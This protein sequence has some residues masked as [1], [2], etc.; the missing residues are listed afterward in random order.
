MMAHLSG[1]V[2]AVLLAV[3]G[4]VVGRLLA[5]A[6][7]GRNCLRRLTTAE[8]AATAGVLGLAA[9]TVTNLVLAYLGIFRPLTVLLTAASLAVI[10][11]TRLR[12]RGGLRDLVPRLTA[13][14]LPIFVLAAGVCVYAVLFRFDAI[15]GM[16]DPGVYTASAIELSRTGDFGWRDRNVAQYGFRPVRQLFEDLH[17]LVAGKPR[18]VR[19]P[20]FYV[21][22]PSGGV[23]EP[24]FLHGYETWLALAYSFGGPQAT[25]CVNALFAALALLAVSCALARVLNPAAGICTAL[26]LA[27][28][29]AEMWFARYTSNELMVQALVWGFLLLYFIMVQAEEDEGV[30]RLAFP[31]VLLAL[32]VAALTKIAAWGFLPVVAFDAALRRAR[33]ITP[34]PGNA[35]AQALWPSPPYYRCAT[36]MPAAHI[37][38]LLPLIAGAAWLHAWLFA[39]FYLFGTWHHTAAHLGMS[40]SF[41]GVLFVLG[42]AAAASAGSLGRPLAF[43]FERLASHKA[44]RVLAPAAA[45]VFGAW[46][47]HSQGRVV[48]SPKLTDVYK[49]NTNVA[50]F[51]LY[52]SGPLFLMAAASLPLMLQWTGR[53]GL[54]LLALLVGV[55]CALLVHRNLDSMHPWGA[56]RWVIVLIPAF[57]A[58]AAFPAAACFHVRRRM[59]QLA[60]AA[61]LAVVVWFAWNAAPQLLRARHYRGA[62]PAVDRLAQ[63]LQPNDLNLMQPTWPVAQ[64][65]AFIKARFDIDCYVQTQSEVAWRQTAA[66][67]RKHWERGANTVY[68]T[69]APLTSDTIRLDLID[70]VGQEPL[71]YEIVRETNRKLPKGSEM[72]SHTLYLYRF[73][74]DR[75]PADWWP[76]KPLVDKRPRSAPPI[77]LKMDGL[78]APYLDGFFGPS[79]C[80]P[81]RVFRWTNGMGAI[82]IGEL[83]RFPLDGLKIRLTVRMGS[84]RP[85]RP[86]PVRVHWFLDMLDKDRGKQVHV[87]DVVAE[88]ADYSL[89]LDPSQLQPD[90]ILYLSSGRNRIDGKMPPGVV[91][92]AVEYLRIEQ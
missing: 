14:D 81:D 11:L 8:S 36:R 21:T 53:R 40:F 55:S 88:L 1:L 20:G 91:G 68:I 29:P 78:A 17:D 35:D 51:A 73:R 67:G 87:S 27:I 85:A 90:S 72:L 56:R 10:A 39:D 74:F 44:M 61:Y 79:P 82:R 23:V 86:E 77:E 22:Q 3:L 60:G 52:F 24:Q 30:P 89:E 46:L 69:D 76:F 28:N 34:Q 64:W 59:P 80:G 84:G 49:E 92:V 54:G 47:L 12:A 57:C 31:V 6:G 19:F 38:V 83:L 71:R 43:Q 4:L 13:R 41:L 50:E 5:A 70:L 65:A 42:T 63:K 45:A 66:I 75:A 26:L 18:W 32:C 9:M 37:W 25:Q 58:A 15:E 7:L 48:P 33:C 16:K 2:C 62:I